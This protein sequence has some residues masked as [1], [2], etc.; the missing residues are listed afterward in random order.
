MRAEF[1]IQAGSD[2]KAG[3]TFTV[4]LP[5]TIDP[6]GI[7]V[8]ENVAFRVM[9]PLGT[10]ALGSYDS[11]TRTITYT[12]TDYITR[13]AVSTFSMISPFF[14][15]RH[16]V[17]YSQNIDIY[18]KIGK[19]SSQPQTFAI[20]YDPYY[21][22]LDTHNPVNIGSMIT[23]LDEATG[24]FVNYIYV[25]PLGKRL[26]QTQLTYTGSGSTIINQDTR[27]QVFE[28]SYPT[29]QMPP[30]WGVDDKSMREVF[31]TNISKSDGRILIDFYD[32][33]LYGKSYIVKISGKSDLKNSDPIHTEAVLQQRYFNYYSYWME[34]GLYVPKGPF[35]E[36]FRF[37]ADVTKK[38]GES[39]ADGSIVVNLTNRKNYI[40]FTKTDAHGN[41]LEATFE[42]RKK[43]GSSDTVTVGSQVNSDKTTGKF[44]FEGLAKGDYELWEVK[45]LTG[46]N[47]PVQA[48]ATFTVN[49]EGE[50]VDKSLAD[51]KI[52]NYKVPELP[53]TGGI[54]V[55]L[56][57]LGG[58]LLCFMA[59]FGKRLKRMK[60]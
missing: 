44:Y 48:V 4:T 50:I 16:T 15:D 25:N 60:P 53:A 54:G 2:I 17:K 45:A 41:P 39:N 34:S 49:D 58:S 23:S 52:V 1:T 24:D 55:L 21:G 9:G 46:F 6:F 32:D 37:T 18:L 51:G 20:N 59:L 7:S 10:L 42:L 40:D 27:V 5:N 8:P 26:E 43:S 14:I 56:Y 3:D 22:A 57:L 19:Q 31:D 11:T 38:S 12:F 47:K 36:S 28:V 35:T 30:S 13:Y 29:V 33:L